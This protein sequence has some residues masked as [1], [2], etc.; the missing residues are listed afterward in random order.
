MKFKKL[1]ALSVAGAMILSALAGCGSSPSSDTNSTASQ[2][3][4]AASDQKTAIVTMMVSG[5][6]QPN[7]FE[8]QILP[9]LVKEKY[10]NLHLEVTKLPDEQYYTALKTRLAS[11]ECPDMILVQPKYAGSNSVLGLAKAGYLAPLD[12]LSVLEKVGKAGT[13]PFTYEGKVYGVPEGVAILGTY[14]N[15][16]IFKKC[17]ITAEPKNWTEFLDVCKKLKAA[18]VQPIVMGD[19]DSYVMQFGLYQIAANQ[20]YPKNKQFDDQLTT[21]KTK[22]TDKDTWDKVLSMYKTL[23][24]NGYIEKNSLG[25]SAQQAIQKF[26]DGEAAMTF[27]GSFNATALNAKGAKDF[28][29]GYFPMPGN[30]VD[31]PI[32]GAVAMGAGP[33]IYANSKHIAECKQILEYWLDGESDLWKAFADSGRVVVAYGYGSDQTNPLFKPFVDLYA[34]NRSFYWCNQGWPAGTE[35]EMEA[36]FGSMIGGQGT[37]VADITKAMQA[38]FDE[39]TAG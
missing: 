7:D 3:S 10:P 12:D 25:L 23:Y 27:D 4:S 14:Y 32:Y 11:G 15:K 30:D 16:D 26:V 24:D 37:K 9:K 6:E 29:R 13:D 33:A 5:T 20:I 1:C 34:Q 17:G 38:K 21:G 36:Q 19:K 39:L 22:F 35:N 28:E 8:T 31:Q 18:G 2:D